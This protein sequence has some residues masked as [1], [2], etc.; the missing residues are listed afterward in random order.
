MG[1]R[2]LGMEEYALL[3][4]LRV[5]KKKMLAQYDR[6]FADAEKNGRLTLREDPSVEL[7]FLDT[8]ELREERALIEELIAKDNAVFSVIVKIDKQRIGKIGEEILAIAES[9]GAKIEDDGSSYKVGGAVMFSYY[10][11][12]EIFRSSLSLNGETEEAVENGYW[13]YDLFFPQDID[14]R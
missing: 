12:G 3:N 1:D 13:L 4:F 2:R 8:R 5:L 9:E 11:A 7:L 10:T 6:V 14:K